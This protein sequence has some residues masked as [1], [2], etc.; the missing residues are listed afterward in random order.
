MAQASRLLNNIYA[1]TIGTGVILK[2]AA[3]LDELRAK[4]YNESGGVVYVLNTVA[5]PIELSLWFWDITSVASD[6]NSTVVKATNIDTGRW[7]KQALT[8]DTNA[9]PAVV[10]GLSFS[11]FT[12]NGMF[13]VPAT[14]TSVTI[15]AIAGGG[16]GG[17]GGSGGKEDTGAEWFGAGGGG[18]GA[19]ENIFKKEFTVIS[20][21]N[22]NI[23]I[24]GG[25]AGGVTTNHIGGVG[26]DGGAT[27]IS[28]LGIYLNG[29]GG[30]GPGGKNEASAGSV[31]AGGAGGIGF[32][33]GAW[34]Q[35]AGY[36]YPPSCGGMGGNGLFAGG[37]AY[38]RGG[39][40]SVG[41]LVSGAGGA[42][43]SFGAGGGGGGGIYD[44]SSLTF[45]NWTSGGPGGAGAAGVV[46]IEW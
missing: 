35:D 36:L 32:P 42:G 26:K 10:Q 16:G 28:T 34:G 12:S 19:G 33:N 23:V 25:G 6:N 13:K 30:G 31:T 14:V 15:T 21:A 9:T 3:S 29:G 27:T 40:A 39:K 1:S 18:G 5:T 11:L 38:S 17:A 20:G 7:I 41:N 46:L 2:A 43:Y 45:G 37:G 22:L 24:G 8:T 44:A 4:D